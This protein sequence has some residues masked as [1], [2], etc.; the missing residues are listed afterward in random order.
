MAVPIVAIEDTTDVLRDAEEAQV[1]TGSIENAV[2][3]ANAWAEEM[4]V[5]ERLPS[6]APTPTTNQDAEHTATNRGS[7]GE[8][9]GAPPSR[10]WNESSP[11]PVSL[12]RALLQLARNHRAEGDCGNSVIHYEDLL[13]RFR[14]AAEV[15]RAL[16]EAAD[17]YRRL[18]R[19]SDAERL[20]Q[21]ATVYASSRQAAQRGLIRLNTIRAAQRRQERASPMP[22][23]QTHEPASLP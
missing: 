14:S 10:V 6:Y 15:P 23:R 22:T 5:P 13:R 18:G 9:A 19:L 4:G 12:S 17:C 3:Q 21:R 8:R 7:E 1:T 2:A 20:L 16:I 11:E